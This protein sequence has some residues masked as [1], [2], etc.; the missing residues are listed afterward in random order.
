M[1]NFLWNIGLHI[2][3]IIFA[4][5]SIL[6]NYVYCIYQLFDSL[7]INMYDKFFEKHTHNVQNI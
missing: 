3:F 5:L 2:L 1:N 4:K 6:I 7:V